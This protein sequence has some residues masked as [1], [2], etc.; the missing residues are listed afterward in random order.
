[1]ASPSPEKLQELW[2]AVTNWRDEH[3]VG[4]P[5]AL[6]QRDSVNESLPELAEVILNIVGYAE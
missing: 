5:E 4:C 6:M 2:T 1:M 3:N